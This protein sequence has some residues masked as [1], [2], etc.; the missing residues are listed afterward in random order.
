MIRALIALLSI[1]IY[2]IIWLPVLL[3]TTIIR[4]KNPQK[5]AKIAHKWAD[6]YLRILLDISGSR[7][8]IRGIEN[9][10]QDGAVLFV[11]N[12]RSIFDIVAACGYT[13]KLTSFI[14]K[15]DLSK[16]PLFSQW[17]S[18]IDVIFLDRNNLKQELKS[19]LLAIDRVKHGSSV[20]I[21]PEGTRNKNP[22]NLNL[23]EFKEG[24]LKIAEKSGCPV[25]PVAIY[26]TSELFEQHFP[27]LTPGHV[28]LEYGKPFY[29]KDL[30]AE[31][32]KKSGAYTRRLI[33]AML[34]QEKA[35]RRKNGLTDVSLR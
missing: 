12:H 8:E 16:I 21:C 31:D 2:M 28:T 15:I 17:M 22:D 27:R 3:V 9:I 34:E 29:T 18:A 24:S 11:S 35:R 6:P 5:A 33:L 4:R 14:A 10:P 23:L 20:W 25:V 19:I 1:I 32:R 7:V 30:A 26:G 13:P